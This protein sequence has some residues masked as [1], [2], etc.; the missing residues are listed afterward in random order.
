MS[1]YLDNAATSWPKP[2]AVYQAV[3]HFMRQVGA[4]PGRGG[5]WREEEAA[6]IADEARAAVAQLFNAVAASRVVFTLN[7]TH[8]I[9]MALKGLL[10][11]GDHVITSSIEHN[12]VWRPLMALRRQGVEVTAVRCAANGWLQPLDVEAAIRHNTRLVAVLH[13]SNVLGTVLPVEEIGA[14]AH[15]H[16]SLLL[17]DA[18]QTAGAHTIDMAAMQ[19]DLLAFAGHKGLYGPHGT[20]GLVVQPGVELDTWIEGGSGIESEREDMPDDLPARLEAGTQNAAGIAGLGAGVGF[21]LE[22]GVE[23]IRAHELEMTRA[24]IEELRGVPGL[25]MLGP[26]DVGRRTA[27]VAVTVDGYAPDQLAAVLDHA[28]D[29]ASRA[30][31][32]CAPQAHR[33]AGTL[34]CG[35]LRFSPGWFTTPDEVEYAAQALLSVVGS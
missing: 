30:G 34:A 22:Q 2:E 10:R 4:T 32:H 23:R 26:R 17:V 19:I 7:A 5:H 35:A 3:E 13:A 31:L 12:A 18:A 25:T 16:G 14:I 29:I 27:V 6:R 21:V 15:R 8:A 1:V 28:F 24:L 11:A 20:G 9:N 33:T